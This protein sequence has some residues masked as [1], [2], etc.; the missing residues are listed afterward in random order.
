M[1]NTTKSFICLA[2]SIILL[3]GS[4]TSKEQSPT[5]QLLDR[6]EQGTSDKFI[7]DI[8][9]APDGKDYFELSQ[10][11]NKI[12]ITGSN[13]SS[14]TTG[15]NWYLKHYAGV[16]LS[17][18]G[19]HADLPDTLPSISEKIRIETDQT[20]RYDFNYCTYSYSMAFWDWE[21]WEK[22]IDW[23]ALHGVNAP[24]ALTGMEAVWYNV[25]DKLDYSKEEINDFIAGPG[26]LAWWHMNNL[27]G[28]G[29]PNP[30][31]WYTQQVALQ[32]KIIT[33]MRELGIEPVFPGYAGMVP[34]N[35]AQKLG[36][37]VSEPG[38]WCG[39]K[40]PAFLQPTDPSFDKIADL[41]YQEMEKLFGKAKYYSIDPFHEGGSTDGV[42]L[43]KA[44]KAIHSAMKRANNEATWVI[45]AWQANPRP[46][47]VNNLPQGD[48]LVLDL[49]SESR[50]MWGDTHSP[51]F[52]ENGYDKHEWLYCMLLNFGGNVGMHGKM[53]RLI[54]GYY[55]AKQHPNGKT[56]KGVGAT[57]EG[58]EN[59]PIMY[60]LLFELPWRS[61]EFSKEDW[62]NDYV[63]ARYGKKD[64]TLWEA[65]KIL[66]NTA[67]QAPFDGTQE[68]T[69]ESVF[70][71]R[72]A[73]DI[74]SASTWGTSKLYYEP[75]DLRAGVEKMIAVAPNYKSNNNFQ[76]DLVDA[77]RQAIADSGN[78][79]QREIAEAFRAKDKVALK[80]KSTNFLTL[81]QEQDKL[82]ATRPE[83]MTGTW[84]EQ[85]KKIGTI[86]QE[87]DLYEWNARTQITSW[88][89]RYAANTGG[90]R[91][92][93]HREWSGI[94]NDLYYKRWKIYLD[95]I[96]T[97]ANEK[98]IPKI[99]F[100]AIEE[101]WNNQKKIYPTNSQAHP[102]ET[103]C[104]IYNRI[105][106]PNN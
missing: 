79:V 57:M 72:P 102:V 30:D 10:K 94:L 99:D 32:K 81:I 52:R 37:N 20:I 53:D 101:D 86:Q 6:I 31:N 39:Y 89:D 65:W 59:N 51:W 92:Y 35:A 78:V 105:F 23:M 58:I 91:D 5:H 7:I 77:V 2:S 42:D 104:E 13:L 96:A 61:T 88:G 45:Q 44:G 82:L 87:K 98:D 38:V 75:Q 49:F 36:L 68:G 60:E 54:S 1:K 50:P 66:A 28:W 47:M 17:W 8:I 103:A 90:L 67:Y 43:D 21:R 70:C 76:Y 63:F 15:I 80:Q 11:G 73:L 27:E 100:Y 46:E 83:F 69:T 16:H 85:A 14:I 34:N 33:R 106:K 18:N 24:L 55:K 19:M 56:L 97:F 62:L 22:E 48:L 29:G 9:Q 25:L 74:H 3:L 40:R 95:T 12:A 26:F 4:C 93:S 71:A 41:Y 84:I 64:S